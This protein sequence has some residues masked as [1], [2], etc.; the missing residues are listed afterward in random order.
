V[1]DPERRKQQS[2]EGSKRLS[3]E[4]QEHLHERSVCIN[5]ILDRVKHCPSDH[6]CCQDAIKEQEEEILVVPVSHAIVD[7]WAVVV[8]LQNA[9][10]ANTA[11]MTSVRLVLCTPLAMSSITRSFCLLQ[12]EAHDVRACAG[13]LW[14]ILPDVVTYDL[15]VWYSPWMLKD[16]PDVADH[17]EERDDV[18]DNTFNQAQRL[19]VRVGRVVQQRY[20]VEEHIDGPQA[21]DVATHKCHRQE[22]CR[23]AKALFCGIWICRIRH[24]FDCLLAAQADG[25]GIGLM[26]SAR[27][28]RLA[29]G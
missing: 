6:V 21:N 11:V 8:H 29:I 24:R 23:L 4:Q 26:S 13:I 20:A 14:D 2:Q 10:P 15:F 18:E 12:V 3:K 5:R 22:L 19:I 1:E 16:A 28:T 17:Q 9:H 27:G 25:L 7:P